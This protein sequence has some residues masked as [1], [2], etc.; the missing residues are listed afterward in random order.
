V[1][2]EL[3]TLNRQIFEIKNEK[4]FETLCFQVF[5][6]QFRYNSLY[7]RFCRLLNKTPESINSISDIPFL[8]VDFFKH[9]KILTAK[10]DY[11]ITFS[12]SSTTG[13]GQSFHYV[14]DLKLYEQSF[15]QG[16]NLFY[17]KPEDYVILALLP[18]YLE[19]EGSS[20]VYMAEK[21]INASQSERSG[22]FLNDLLKLKETVNSLK[23][24][25]KKVLVLGVTYAL[26]DFAEQFP[27]AL[28]NVTIMETGGMKGRRKEMI[29]EEVHAELK[30]AFGVDAIHS[31]YGMTELL[32]QAYSKG[33][34]IFQCPPWMR[35]LTREINDPFSRQKKGQTGGADIIDLA[36]IYSCSFLSTSDLAKVNENGT[37]EILGRFDNSDLRGCNLLVQ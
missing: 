1:Q 3:E 6:L 17:G 23:A 32:S 5:S 29:R 30:K 9:Y 31:E 33:D 18:S 14:K 19:R 24:S 20:L 25:G 7:G 15:F 37:F 26:L 27:G 12:S 13:T 36:N 35:I 16:F 4:E 22:F 34:G 10:E 8:P 2:T 11:E 28:E 21:L